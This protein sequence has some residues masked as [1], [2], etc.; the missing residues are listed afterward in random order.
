MSHP[1]DGP[2]GHNHRGEKNGKI[3]A[4]RTRGGICSCIRS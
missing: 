1:Y 2:T 3:M 4:R